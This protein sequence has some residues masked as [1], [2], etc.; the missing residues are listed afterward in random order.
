MR[1]SIPVLLHFTKYEGDERHTHINTI[2]GIKTK[3]LIVTSLENCYQ[4]I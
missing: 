4:F 2:E 1:N 3:K